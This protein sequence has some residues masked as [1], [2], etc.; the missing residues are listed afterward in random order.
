MS[1]LYTQTPMQTHTHTHRDTHTHA[2]TQHTLIP[3]RTK[4]S[5]KKRLNYWEVKNS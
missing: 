3:Y 2:H 1:H 5:R 4:Q